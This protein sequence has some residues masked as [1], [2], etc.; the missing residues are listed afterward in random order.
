MRGKL[1]V[2]MGSIA[3]VVGFAVPSSPASAVNSPAVPTQG[4]VEWCSP[5]TGVPGR[6]MI[7]VVCVAVDTAK[8]A[9]VPRAYVRVAYQNVDKTG[10]AH[11]IAISKRIVINGQASS[12]GRCGATVSPGKAGR[13]PGSELFVAPP[14]A[15][16]Q[17]AADIFVAGP[18]TTIQ[19]PPRRVPG[20][21]PV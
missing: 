11:Y 2:L 1:P 4:V 7:A 18:A 5:V 19:S 21:V 6:Y 14:G 12:V 13:C 10:Y 3:L 20:E 15:L 16:I 9:D 8:Q 17:G